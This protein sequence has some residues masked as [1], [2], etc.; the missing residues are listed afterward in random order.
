MGPL[1]PVATQ[2]G[3]ARGHARRPLCDTAGPGQPFGR[4][5]PA[6]PSSWPREAFDEVG[7]TRHYSGQGFGYERADNRRPS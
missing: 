1:G 3:T 7:R 5:A 4:E 2:V 6:Q